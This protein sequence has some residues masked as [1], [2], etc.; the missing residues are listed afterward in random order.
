MFDKKDLVVI[1]VAAFAFGLVESLVIWILKLVGYENSYLASFFI[2]SAIIVGVALFLLIPI[3]S[4]KKTL[5]ISTV[6]L[7]MF[8]IANSFFTRILG[9]DTETYFW[10]EVFLIFAVIIAMIPFIIKAVYS[11]AKEKPLENPVSTVATITN[12]YQ[13]GTT[14][15][16]GNIH[17]YDMQVDLDVK[18]SDSSIFKGGFVRRIPLGG[19]FGLYNI[20][21]EINVV[22]NSKNEKDVRIDNNAPGQ[23]KM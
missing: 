3:Y 15:T 4:Q 19:V 20:G 22:Y 17:Y 18:R 11:P 23:E 1:A 13:T 9:F 6:I 12:F 10:M 14:L 5:I 7:I 8:D 21:N 16:M 2:A